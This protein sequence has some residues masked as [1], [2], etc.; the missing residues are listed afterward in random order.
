MVTKNELRDMIVDKLGHCP[1]GVERAIGDLQEDAG[2]VRTLMDLS[3]LIADADVHMTVGGALRAIADGLAT[4]VEDPSELRRY[5]RAV[6]DLISERVPIDSFEG[7]EYPMSRALAHLKAAVAAY[8]RDD[9]IVAERHWAMSKEAV[10]EAGV[11]SEVGAGLIHIYIDAQER[12][13][14]RHGGYRGE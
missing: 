3:E 9:R 7:L 6:D 13:Y 12:Y 2:G 5:Q 14:T 11:P 4:Y 1:P 8:E 10:D